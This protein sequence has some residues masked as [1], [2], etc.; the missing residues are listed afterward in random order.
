LQFNLQ[1]PICN[2]VCVR[3]LRSPWSGVFFGSATISFDVTAINYWP[4]ITNKLDMDGTVTPAIDVRDVSK[5]FGD[6]RVLDSVCLSVAPGEI[7][8]LLG[9]SGS[10]KSTL[11]KI[12][13][14]IEQPDSG[15]VWLSGENVTGRPAHR[16]RVHTV[17]Q[18]YALF[19]HL[20]VARNVAFPLAVAGVSKTDRERLVAEALSWVQMETMLNRPVQTLSGGERQ[21]VALA[22]ALVDGIPCVLLD[23]P[24]S[25]LDPHLRAQTLE[26]LQDV[27]SRLRVTYLYVTH[28]RSEAL[29]AAHRIGVLRQG[30]LEQVGTPQEIYKRPASP[31]VASFI[32]PINWLC[33]AVMASNA[34][35]GL[36][37]ADGCTVPLDAACIP[38]TG[39]IR[40]GLRPELLRVG[41]PGFV[42]AQ[43]TQL[44]F[45]GAAVSVRLQLS[46][47][48]TITAELSGTDRQ[49]ALGEIVPVH[50]TPET[51]LIFPEVE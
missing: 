24:L 6:N 39:R 25:A 17:F 36:R 29:R 30:K 27:Q 7:F 16:R 4:L 41:E 42:R 20:N 9:A 14:G 35:I 2:V 44:Q 33:G 28:D 22:R 26:F 23:E 11:L 46:D 51:A 49:P 38:T 47:G 3:I 13:S 48:L 37:L 43:V 34:T 19:P 21:R 1:L 15:E 18:N 32:G 31:F 12:I 5:R 45:S 8:A 40:L 50:W 10:G